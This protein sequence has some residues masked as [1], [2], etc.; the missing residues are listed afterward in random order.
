[1]IARFDQ[2]Q[3]LR[4]GHRRNQRLEFRAGAVLISRTADEQFGFGA[5]PKEFVRIHSRFLTATRDRNHGSS[6]ADRRF[7]ARIRTTRAQSHRSAERKSGEDERQMILAVQ[8]VERST[9]V[10]DFAVALIV[11]SFTQPCATKIEAQYRES[12]TVQRL[13]GV[14]DDFIMQ[15]STEERVRMADHGR[16]ARIPGAG[17][18]QRFQAAARAVEKERAYR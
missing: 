6:H 17:V 1:M 9:H 18:E 3:L 5:V 4:I 8:P 2:H 15:S 12:K 7:Y 11:F 13:H 14:K 16:M 10:V